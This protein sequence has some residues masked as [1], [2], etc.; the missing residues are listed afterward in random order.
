MPPLVFP[1]H[2]NEGQDTESAASDQFQNR[3]RAARHRAIHIVLFSLLCGEQNRR[4]S[5]FRHNGKGP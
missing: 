1:I 5:A 2:A 4:N 3:E